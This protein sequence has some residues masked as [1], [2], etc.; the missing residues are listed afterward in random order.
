MRMTYGLGADPTAEE[1][2]ASL[3]QLTD[4]LSLPGQDEFTNELES[5]PRAVL[6]VNARRLEWLQQA[7]PK[8]LPPTEE[9][10]TWLLMAGRGA[11]KTRSGAEEMWWGAVW[12]PQRI[13]V[14]GPTLA[15]V[16]KTCFEGE[17]G[18][19][20]VI[21]KSLIKGFNRTSCEMWVH[22]VDGIGESYFV[23]YSS[24]EPERLRG[25]QHHRAWCDEMAAWRYIEE[26]WDMLQFG[27]RLGDFPDVVVTTTPRP[28]GLVR[29]LLADPST[30]I[31]RES[32]F[33]NEGNLPASFIKTVKEKYEGTRLGEQELHAKLLDDNPYALWNS[34]L[35]DATRRKKK[36]TDYQRIVVAVDPPITSGEDADECGIICAGKY[37]GPNDM[38][39]ADVLEDWSLK[40]QTPQGWATRAVSMYHFFKADCIVAETNQGGDMVESVI[41][42]VDPNVPVKQVK[43]TRGKVVRA[44]PVSMLYEQKRAHHIGRFAKLEDQMCDFTS[45]FDKD[46][47]GYSPDRVDALVWAMTELMIEGGDEYGMLGAV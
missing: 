9:W 22:N 10:L 29:K 31:S 47:F 44:E 45:D 28:V 13:A 37:K 41:H 26:T 5:L 36:Q 8:Q 18:L 11:G 2:L 27:L 20:N 40:G 21:P 15:D 1:F 33:A 16:R 30:R 46:V 3:D 24:E 7:R 32:T 17:S 19:L 14:V 12:E 39:H 25:P 43:A 23:G 38:D 6:E 42:N 35:L 4:D 34:V